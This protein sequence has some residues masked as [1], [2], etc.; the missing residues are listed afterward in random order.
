MRWYQRFFRR[1]L[2]EKH[3]DAELRFHL[4]QQIACY[5]SA[6]M[7]PEEARR[8][9]WLEFGGL[10]Q[11]KE[12]CR[13][14]G[15]AHVLETLAQDVRYG[16]RQLRRS[17]G[18]A[19]VAVLTLALGIGANT[20]IFALVNAVILRSLPVER[21]GEL[22][23]VQMVD[24]DEGGGEGGSAFSNPLWEQ[25][26]DQ[27][28]VFSRVFAWGDFDKFELAGGGH[29]SCCPWNLGQRWLFQRPRAAPRCGTLDCRVRRT[30]WVPGSRRAQLWLLAGA[31]RRGEGCHW[32]HT[33]RRPPS[34]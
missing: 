16:L 10:D 30:A 28:D 17:P 1:G 3:L 14:V 25:L 26:R 23:Q 5:V 33:L 22:Y 20:A 4:E 32:Q 29:D 7:K 19:A 13:D 12:E 34:L 21:P 9:A 18:F 15:A 8:R 2:T 27:Q 24:A 31:L 11:V 6:G